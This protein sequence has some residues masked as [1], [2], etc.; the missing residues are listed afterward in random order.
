QVNEQIRDN[1]QF[2]DTKLGI[3]RRSIG[4]FP[5]ISSLK[6]QKQTTNEIDAGIPSRWK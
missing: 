2:Y 6:M 1:K 4:S 5:S 3:K